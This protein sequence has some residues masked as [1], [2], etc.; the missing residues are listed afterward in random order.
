M[1]KCLL[2]RGNIASHS[3]LNKYLLSV[4]LSEANVDVSIFQ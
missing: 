1:L 2:V 3:T 4:L